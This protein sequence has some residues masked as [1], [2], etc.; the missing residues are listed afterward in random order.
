MPLGS[1][2]FRR[3]VAL[4]AALERS[5]RWGRRTLLSCGTRLGRLRLYRRL[6]C[7]PERR[8]P[9]SAHLVAGLAGERPL[10]RARPAVAGCAL[11]E[12]YP[13]DGARSLVHRLCGGYRMAALEARVTTVF[14]VCCV[15]IRAGHVGQEPKERRLTLFELPGRLHS[16]ESTRPPGHFS[17]VRCVCK[18]CPHGIF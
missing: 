1:E 15:P 6:L 2:A 14:S 13:L 11:Y 3:M 16:G 7:F 12:S 5:G 4:R 17:S 8:A 9:N 10:A 18:E